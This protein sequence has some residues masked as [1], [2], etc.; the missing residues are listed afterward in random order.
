[1]RFSKDNSYWIPL[2]LIAASGFIGMRFSVL[3][4]G[5]GSDASFYPVSAAIALAAAAAVLVFWHSTA[6]LILLGIVTSIA[7]LLSGIVDISA[8][9]VSRSIVSLVLSG[10]TAASVA[11]LIRRRIE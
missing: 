9:D 6:A 5:S 11:F 8:G 10:L 4:A 1:M 7:Q 2:A 3:D